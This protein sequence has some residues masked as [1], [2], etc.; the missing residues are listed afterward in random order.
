MRR[1]SQFQAAELLVELTS[2]GNLSEHSSEDLI[3]SAHVMVPR[4]AK[5]RV[6]RVTVAT[7]DGVSNARGFTVRR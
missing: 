6:V 2:S 3:C 5:Y 1:P 7:R 4:T